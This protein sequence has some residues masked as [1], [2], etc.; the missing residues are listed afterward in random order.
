MVFAIVNMEGNQI[1][2]II[3]RVLKL[4]FGC[5]SSVMISLLEKF[6]KMKDGKYKKNLESDNKIA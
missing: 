5:Y 3:G 4:K 6:T 1:L 2:I